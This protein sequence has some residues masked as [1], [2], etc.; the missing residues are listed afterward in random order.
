MYTRERVKRL[1]GTHPGRDVGIVVSRRISSDVVGS[2][3][4]RWVAADVLEVGILVDTD[5][6]EVHMHRVEVVEKRRDGS[7]VEREGETGKGNERVRSVDVV[8]AREKER[9]RRTS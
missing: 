7:E 8:R 6:V 1:V 2:R 3:S 4:I 9:E 5:V